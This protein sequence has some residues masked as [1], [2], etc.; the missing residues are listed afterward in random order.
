MR[1]TAVLSRG[2]RHP[3]TLET[4]ELDAPRPDEILV[5]ITASGLCHTDLA[6]R[7]LAPEGANPLVLGHEGAGVVEEVGREVRGV[8]PG[9][10]V[11]LSYR[12]CGACPNCRDGRPAYCAGMLALNNGGTRPDGSTTLRQGDTPLVGSFFGQSSFASHVL[13]T[14]DNTVVVGRE[15]DLGTL[16]PLGCGVQTGAGAVLNVLRPEPGATLAIFGM[17]SVGLS[18]LLAARTAGVARVLAVD[19]LPE[20]RELAL[21]LGAELALDPGALEAGTELADAVRGL[22]DGGPDHALDTTGNPEVI[23]QGVKA[24]AARGTLVV[25]GL[26]PNELT[27]DVQDLMY[28]GKSLRGCVEG[29]SVPER[30]IPELLELHADGRFPVERLVTRYRFEDINQAVAD[31][32]AGRVVKP[33]LTW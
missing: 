2:P 20:R 8:A 3:F 10:R 25:V 32:L 28:G 33:V 19:L 7:S 22:L 29:D 21:A 24:L 26:G 31:Q 13:T 9:D 16:A 27:L 15:T 6:V 14:V 17:G 30:F 18:A 1:I 23:A 12:R 5:R 4:V 11:L